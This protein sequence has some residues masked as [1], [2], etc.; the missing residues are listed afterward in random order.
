MRAESSA[1]T[2]KF[3]DAICRFWSCSV[4]DT[5]VQQGRTYSV[6]RIA[7]SESSHSVVSAG[8][9]LIACVPRV[10]PYLRRVKPRDVDVSFWIGAHCLAARN[11]DVPVC[12]L[13]PAFPSYFRSC[14][15]ESTGLLS[16]YWGW[17]LLFLCVCL[18]SLHLHLWVLNSRRNFCKAQGGSKWEWFTSTCPCFRELIVIFFWI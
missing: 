1:I 17:S 10:Q 6:V 14:P 4:N 15:F 12:G 16:E 18:S 2:S 13:L 11:R 8:A 9:A 5:F 7:P 3:P